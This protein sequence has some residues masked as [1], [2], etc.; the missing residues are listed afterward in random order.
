MNG[1]SKGGARPQGQIR[2]SQII[3]T[4]GPGALVDLPSYAAIIGGLEHWQGVEKPIFEER[5]IGKLRRMLEI[6][7]LKL[8]APPIDPGDPLAPR[9]GITAWMFP[10]W[11][12]AQYEPG[13][14]A[15]VRSR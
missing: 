14:G 13:P 15:K 10:E 6:P 2:Q 9:T 3:T 1:R 12:V 8:F 5:L 11:F 7:G 4:F